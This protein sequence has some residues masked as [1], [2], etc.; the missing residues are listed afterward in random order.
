MDMDALTNN[1]RKN[2][3]KLVDSSQLTIK[4]AAN[5]LKMNYSTAKAIIKKYRLYGSF[6][7]ENKI[8]KR[9]RNIFKIKEREQILKNLKC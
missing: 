4:N 9:R 5:L 1:A 6:N 3:I 8:S 2:L 7:R